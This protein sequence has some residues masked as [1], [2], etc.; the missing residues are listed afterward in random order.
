M[1]PTKVNSLDFEEVAQL[2]FKYGFLD[3]DFGALSAFTR[4]PVTTL[5][6]ACDGSLTKVVQRAMDLA[7]EAEPDWP[8]DAATLPELLETNTMILW[9]FF[10]K[11]TGYAR[12]LSNGIMGEIAPR[13]LADFVHLLR[14]HNLSA[15]DIA[16]VLR[17]TFINA[18]NDC[19]N[20]EAAMTKTGNIAEMYSEFMQDQQ[21]L[22]IQ[23]TPFY[24]GFRTATEQLR[25]NNPDLS[26]KE[27][28]D[29]EE[30]VA[31]LFFYTDPD[32]PRQAFHQQLM[33]S[34]RGL[35]YSINL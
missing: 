21:G 7:S 24:L 8:I 5:M 29:T 17:T 12:L 19:A 25:K 27:L 33:L 31:S 4:I 9:D 23:D 20:F 6:Q 14:R 35:Q 10:H 18:L 15:S 30:Q 22:A 3:V 26:E 13:Q 28:T 1:N 34:I 16:L 32:I 11:N 2:I